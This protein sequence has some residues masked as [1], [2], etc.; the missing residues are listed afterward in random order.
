MSKCITC[1]KTGNFGYKNGKKEYCA[2]HAQPGMINLKKSVCMYE[3]CN[4]TKSYGYLKDKKEGKLIGQKMFC[5][6][7]AEN[8]MVNLHGKTCIFEDCLLQ[9]S[10][11]LKNGKAQYCKKHAKKDMIDVLNVRNICKYEN[12]TIRASYGNI[13]GKPERCLKHKTVDMQDVTKIKCSHPNCL[14]IPIYGYENCKAEYCKS[15]MLEGMCD[16]VN[17]KCK[18][19]NC[20]KRPYFG[21]SSRD[22]CSSHRK[23]DMHKIGI[24]KCKFPNC[25]TQPIFGNLNSKPEYCFKHK[26]V[27][28]VDLVN[29]KCKKKNCNRQ[30]FFGYQGYS[31]EYCI[32]HKEY[33]M[34]FKPLSF[35]KEIDKNCSY[36]NNLIHYNE[37]FCKFCKTY[38]TLGTTLK[39]H[40]KEMKIKSLLEKNKINFIHDSIIGESKKRPDFLIGENIILEVDENQHKYKTYPCKC[41]T[42]RMQQIY[43]DNNKKDLLFVRYNPDNYIPSY[44]VELSSTEREKYLIKFLQ[45][46]IKTMNFKGIKVVYLFFDGFSIDSIEFENLDPY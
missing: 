41:E 16:V 7:H 36:C 6:N 46:A 45:H 39:K 15:H 2:I 12:C 18:F 20:K 38:I 31:P 35:P 13:G 37:S 25:N 30:P 8:G 44:G 5:K 29:R 19:P 34:V 32:Q 14:T 21:Y 4:K 22:F 10:F 11:G 43:H 24:K 26:T 40:E 23:E 27:D 9:C 42:L 28:M 33:R 3:G 1:L 17:I